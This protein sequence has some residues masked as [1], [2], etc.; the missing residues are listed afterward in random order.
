MARYS[1]SPSKQCLPEYGSPQLCLIVARG[2]NGVIG[3]DGDLPWRLPEDLKAFKRITKGAP[4]V[5]GR[6]TWDSLPKKPLPGR[7]NIVVS[8]NGQFLAPG[9]RVYA[10]VPVAVAAAMAAAA[11]SES[12]E[13]FVIGGA[14]LYHD[15]LALA[16][17]LYV[18]DVD[19][20]PEGDTMFPPLDASDW[21]VETLLTHPADD[22]HDHA[23]ALR[24]WDRKG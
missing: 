8:R 6:K 16:H 1:A 22:R 11:V 3:V 17:R 4:L 9:A 12:E 13:V 21:T 14:T 7:P 18:T 10:S 5:M 24:R 19:A 23:F 15:A 2:S 20:A